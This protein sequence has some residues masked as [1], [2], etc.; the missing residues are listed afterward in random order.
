MEDK[1]IAIVTEAT[2]R[3]LDNIRK[4]DKNGIEFWAARDLQELLGYS[5]WDNFK[6]AID[7]AKMACESVGAMASHHF[8]DIG[9]MVSLG[10]R[11]ERNIDDVALSRYACYLIAMNGESSKPE[12]A[13]AQIYFA[14]QTRK[15]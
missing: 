13:A 9:K 15:Q 8:A 4:V 3:T 2:I 12:I 6:L 11:A 5:K 14:I 7:K 1:D 10:S